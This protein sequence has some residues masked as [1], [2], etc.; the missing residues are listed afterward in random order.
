MIVVSNTSPLTN[1]AAIGQLDLLQQLYA[2][3]YIPRGVWH[4]LNAD[5]EKWPGRNEVEQAEWIRQFQVQNHSLVR[6]LL[7]DLDQGEA[8]A[9]ALAVEKEADIILIDEREGRFA[10]KRQGLNVTGIIGILL[11][12]KKQ[13]LLSSIKPHLDALRQTAGFF[14]SDSLYRFAVSE[15]EEL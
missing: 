10:A 6:A 14:I 7:V 9:I 2:E 13:S 4:E 8:E 5:G 1:L 12:A 3:V 11:I 15:A